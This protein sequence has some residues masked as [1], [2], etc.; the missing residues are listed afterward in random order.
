MTIENPYFYKY[1][2]N[3]YLKFSKRLFP[4]LE[5]LDVEKLGLAKPMSTAQKAFYKLQDNILSKKHAA[6]NS[7]LVNSDA[8]RSD[9]IAGIKNYLLA[10]QKKI[11]PEW[12]VNAR[13]LIEAVRKYNWHL[14]LESNDQKTIK[15][16]SLL[17]DIQNLPQLSEAVKTLNMKKWID[18]LS[19]AQNKF[20]VALRNSIEDIPSNENCS[21]TEIR[22]SFE[23]IFK[24][25]DLMQL[26]QP[27]PVYSSVIHDINAVIYEFNSEVRSRKTSDNIHE[28]MW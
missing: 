12:K 28:A 21:C 24:F 3:D 20:E 10:C 5:Q 8:I 4:I 11:N 13:L 17:K 6:C 19:E 2:A 7:G 22:N 16:R 25:I 27:N 1:Q 26:I 23:L 15:I 18:E 14:E 9:A